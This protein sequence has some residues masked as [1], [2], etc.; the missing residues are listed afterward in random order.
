MKCSTPILNHLVLGAARIIPEIGDSEPQILPLITATI[1]T[2][3]QTN[4]LGAATNVEADNSIL[5]SALQN[6]AVSSGASVT[7]ICTLKKGLYTIDLT[8]SGRFV[9][10]PAPNGVLDAFVD[11]VD[12]ALTQSVNLGGLFAQTL[13]AQVFSRR[14]RVA[15]PATFLLRRRTTA[16]GAAQTMEI[17]WGI[18]VERHL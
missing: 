16:T 18:S 2:L 5:V 15:L 12:E 1:E 17:G 9:G 7:T 8:I 3:A 4:V 10:T 13:T 6:I 11:I 14:F